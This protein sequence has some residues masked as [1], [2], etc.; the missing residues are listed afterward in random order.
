MTIVLWT[1]KMYKNIFNVMLLNLCH[2]PFNLNFIILLSYRWFDKSFSVVFFK[3]G[4]AGING[5]HSWA[6]AP[7]LSHLWEVRNMEEK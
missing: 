6:D 5:E 3:N 7:V 1:D 2:F 4:K